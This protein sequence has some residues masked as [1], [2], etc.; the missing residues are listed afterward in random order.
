MVNRGETEPKN[1]LFECEK[2]FEHISR[3]KEK[4]VNRGPGVDVERMESRVG[5]WHREKGNL[6]L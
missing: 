1:K 2:K 4:I 5:Q 6:T 3:L